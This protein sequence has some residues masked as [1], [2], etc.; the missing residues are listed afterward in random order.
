MIALFAS[1][2]NGKV[3]VY[4]L[5]PAALIVC[6]A[7]LIAQRVTPFTR[8]WVFLFPL[9]AIFAAWG[10]T[11]VLEAISRGRARSIASVAATA[12]VCIVVSVSVISSRSVYYSEETGTLR[13]AEQIT[14]FLSSYLLQDDRVYAVVPS[15]GPLL[16]YFRRRDLS[17][18]YIAK[19]ADTLSAGGRIVI[20]VNKTT[21]SLDDMLNQLDELGV[22]PATYSD[23]QL[24]QSY[25]SADLYAIS[26]R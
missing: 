24:V 21:S 8:V 3:P 6:G 2:R 20:V 22:S 14:T 18:S 11:V 17:N 13:D 9:Y 16:Y 15:D 1:R 12:I 4:L 7:I 23:P 5:V 26:K 19:T 10:V 25:E